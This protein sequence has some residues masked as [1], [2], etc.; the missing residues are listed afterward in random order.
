M[1]GVWQ[2]MLVP[3]T[4]KNHREPWMRWNETEKL[5]N[6]ME[7]KILCPIPFIPWDQ[8]FIKILFFF[9]RNNTTRYNK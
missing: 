1:N 6:P 4:L 3:S 2:K 7:R 8:R 5:F 9:V